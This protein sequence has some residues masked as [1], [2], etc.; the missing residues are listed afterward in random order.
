MPYLLQ[1]RIRIIKYTLSH[2]FN[3]CILT[4]GSAWRPL[5]HAVEDYPL[6][7][8]DP[9]TMTSDHLIECDHVR[10]K[11]KGANLYAHHDDAHR[12]YY[13]GNHQPNEVLLMKMFDSDASV[14]A[15][16]K[17]YTEN[18]TSTHQAR[19][20]IARARPRFFLSSFRPQGFQT[21]KKHRSPSF[22]LQ[23]PRSRLRGT[24]GMS[25]RNATSHA[26]DDRYHS[27]PRLVRRENPVLQCCLPNQ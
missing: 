27:T 13:L 10:R 16:S 15:K 11:F 24:G 7:F 25:S 9:D 3:Q 4:E 17:Y 12:W 6:A 20:T 21:E 1:G 5:E 14:R 23:L 2:R 26:S 19:L 8:C 18:L 22:G